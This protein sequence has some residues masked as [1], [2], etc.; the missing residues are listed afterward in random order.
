M[1]WENQQGPWGKSQ[2]PPEIDEMLERLQARI[3]N[4]F[5]GKQTPL[6]WGLLALVVL[7]W[8]ATGIFMINQ[9]EVGVIQRFGK[10]NR[11]V[12]PGLHWK[13]PASIEKVTHVNVHKVYTQE[14]GLRTVR[15]GVDTEYA[16]EQ[17]YED[18]SLMLTGDLNCV[19]VPWVVRYQVGDPVKFLFRVRDVKGILRDLAESTMRRIVGDHSLDEVL[20][21][22]EEIASQAQAALQEALTAADSGLFLQTI[23]LG[24]TNVPGPV[25]PSFNEVNSAIQEKEKLI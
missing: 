5:G 8:L 3:R 1:S 10:Y 14:F 20:T 22:R 9:S 25:Q 16:P 24:R 11:T 18:E 13:L 6:I 17:Y 12:G 23:E 4:L 7:L 15:A 21:K 2:R 19:L